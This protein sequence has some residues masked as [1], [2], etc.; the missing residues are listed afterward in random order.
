MKGGDSTTYKRQ[1]IPT[2]GYEK[3]TLDERDDRHKAI[4]PTDTNTPKENMGVTWNAQS[5]HC[6]LN[7]FYT[8]HI[9]TFVDEADLSKKRWVRISGNKE[10]EE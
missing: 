5:K 7:E 2:T 8:S 3:I 9:Y 4:H 6:K 1:D 10:A